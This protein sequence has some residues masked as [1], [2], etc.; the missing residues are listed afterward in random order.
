MPKNDARLL[1]LT[2]A[3]QGVWYGQTLDQQNPQYN[4][5]ECIEIHG[6]LDE[7]AFEAAL[8]RA[9]N[10]CESL[11]TEFVTLDDVVYQRVVRKS[12]ERCRL[13]DLSGTPDAVAAAERYMAGDMAMVDN[14]TSPS[15]TLALLKISP[16]LHYWYIRYHH[17]AMDGLGGAVFARRVAQMYTAAVRGEHVPAA[18]APLS[19]LV[20]DELAYRQSPDF[21][22]DRAYWMQKFADISPATQGLDDH[23]TPWRTPGD[24]FIPRRSSHRIAGAGEQAS[25]PG[26]HLHGGEVLP[27]HVMGGL[28]RLASEAR[29]TWPVV[30]VSAVAAFLGRVTGS[31]DVTIGLASN[32]RRGSLL[33]TVGMTANILLLRIRLTPGMTVENLLR[34]VSTEM[35]LALRHRRY[36]REQLARDLRITGE[37]GVFSDVVV[38]VMPYEYDLDFAGSSGMSRALSIG[39]VDDVSVFISERSEQTGPLIGF[40]V[41]RDLY[42]S[43]DALPYQQSMTALI[44]EFARSDLDSPLSLVRAFDDSAATSILDRGRGAVLAAPRTESSDAACLQDVFAVWAAA[45]PE[46]VAVSGSGAGLTY[47]ALDEVSADLGRC[48]VGLGV[49]GEGC[50]GVLM[51]RSAGVVTASL[52]VVR[53]GGVYVPLDGRWPD[54][55]LRQAAAVTDLR[56]L[57]VDEG[58]A[59]HAWVE[60]MRG[61]VPVVVVDAVGRVIAGAPEKQGVLPS[62]MGGDRLAYVMFTSGSTGVPKGVGVSH[63]DVVALAADSA[64]RDTADAV[65]MHSAYVFDASTFEIWVPLLGGGRI[66]V[67]PRGQ[68]EPHVLREVVTAEGVTALFMT[69]ALFNV[70]AETG[71]DALT[72]VRVVCAGGELAT[73]GGMQQVAAL[74]P[75]THVLHVYGPTE[76]TTFA[77]RFTVTADGPAGSPAIGRALD[78]MHV[79]VLDAGLGLVPQG[80]VGE[81]YVAGR[82]ARGYVGRPGLT[83][84]RF[85]ADPFDVSGGRMYRTG[86]L[87]RWNTQ[88]ELEYIARAD[89]QVKLRGYRIE[90]GEVEG[91]LMAAPSVA[92]ACVVVREDLAGDRRLVAYVVPAANKVLEQTELATGIARVLPEYMVPSAFVVLEAL[93]LTPNG[94]V[95]RRA[96]PAPDIAGGDGGR[97]PRSAEEEILCGLFADVLGRDRVSVHDNFFALGGH[98]LLATRLVSR[99]R[100]ALG[101]E[102][103]IRTLFEHP[104]PAELAARLHVADQARA[105]LVQETRPALLP[106]SFAQQRLWFLS[107]LE[108]PSATY[109]IPLVLDFDGPLDVRALRAAFADVVERHETLR[110]V[111]VEE[112]GVPLQHVHSAPESRGPIGLSIE[113]PPA[114]S[115][116]DHIERWSEET[117]RRATGEVFDLSRDAAVRV[118]LLRLSARRH[119]LV[120]VLHHIAADGWS[121]APLARDL[122]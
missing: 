70:I 65:L 18:A 58:G 64:W 48:L 116:L 45:T 104:T 57:V 85:L 77:T 121:L 32:G 113:A 25:P 71:S 98:S 102:L 30:F 101:V 6:P 62:P 119:V 78:G 80:V 16:D 112:D 83:S 28:R 31:R 89:G 33:R 46:A 9:S 76:T 95:D 86:D 72:G 105:R 34:A 11:N 100:S 5:G 51:D 56:A 110:T 38:N 17:I 47:S 29:T 50:V 82:V 44:K 120:L 40:D 108:G 14:L 22:N 106:L 91:V 20:E 66:V 59:G 96:L 21:E 111:F 43:D 53:S 37:N 10:E 117:I 2:A 75:D 24:G 97:G 36:S 60:E 8:R 99:V 115:D 84:T 67:A 109:N 52:A 13:V 68:L 114:G 49:R 87:V 81:L 42:H 19:A 3:Q 63:A 39:P 1:P 61:R 92:S 27:P 88:G 35:R 7:N 122:G 41:N 94:K 79:Y 26:A 54:E 103:E 55:R 4:I 12:A 74:L 90:P 23:P 107:R 69:T 73:P 93:P 15:H 118:R